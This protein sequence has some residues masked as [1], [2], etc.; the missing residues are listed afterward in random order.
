MLRVR[1]DGISLLRKYF[2][3]AYRC[4]RLCK[5]SRDEYAFALAYHSLIIPLQNMRSRILLKLVNSLSYIMRLSYPISLNCATNCV[6]SQSSLLSI[7]NK[8]LIHNQYSLLTYLTNYSTIIDPNQKVSVCRETRTHH[9]L[10]LLS[11]Y[12]VFLLALL[13]INL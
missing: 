13:L 3:P 4:K 12:K 9:P 8:S 10:L 6:G 7:S 1:R 2:V 11:L 5:W